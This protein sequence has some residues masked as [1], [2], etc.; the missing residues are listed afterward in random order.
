MSNK[1]KVLWFINTPLDL[2]DFSTNFSKSKGWLS[3]LANLVNDDVDLHIASVDPYKKN[4][5]NNKVSLYY[6]KPSLW[7]IRMF[8]YSFFNF[9][10]IEKGILSQSKNLILKLNPD[11]IH[12]HGTEKSYIKIN[13]FCSKLN[14]PLLVSIQGI[15]TVINQ[16]YNVVFNQ[17]DFYTIFFKKGFKKSSFIPKPL[18]ILKNN[19]LRKSRIEKNGLQKIYFI[20]GRTE[21]DKNV[22][23]ILSPHAKYFTVDRILKDKFYKHVWDSN[24]LYN[25]KI[26]LMTTM[27]ETV[28]KGFETIYKTAQ[29]FDNQNIDFEWRIAGVNNNSW[30]VKSIES[31]FK[32]KKSKN[33]IFLGRVDESKIISNLLKSTFYVMTSH[34]EN[35]PNNLA[36]AMLV[37]LPC[38]ASFAGGTNTYIENN[39]SGIMFQSGDYYGLSGLILNLYA[40]PNKGE[41]ISRNARLYSLKRHNKQTV[42]KQLLN[43]YESIQKA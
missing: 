26:I 5:K 15:C 30:L 14:I 25:K 1:L 7:F 43:A 24:N 19:M 37:G 41:K 8:F 35:S 17:L 12:I 6:L 10:I 2:E 31:K 11:I 20:A 3:L 9:P 13:E 38:I 29:I 23:K 22:T 40:N 32:S 36:E 39:I 4:V 27:S 16:K 28:F 21:W 33:I 18:I 42:K 34:I